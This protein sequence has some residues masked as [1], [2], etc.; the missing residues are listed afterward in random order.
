[1]ISVRQGMAALADEVVF[2]VSSRRRNELRL[3]AYRLG[4]RD[5]YARAREDELRWVERG[6]REAEVFANSSGR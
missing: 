1:M 5:G 2:R 4:L 6:I 3:Q